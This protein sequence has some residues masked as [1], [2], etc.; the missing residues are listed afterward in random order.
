MNQPFLPLLVEPAE[1]EAKLGASNLLIV[2]LNRAEVYAQTHLPGAVRLEY[3]D[4]TLSN[5]PAMGLLPDAKRLSD[6]MSG[7]G[8][9]PDKHVVAYDAEGGSRAARLLWT[10]D[11]IGHRHYSLLNGGLL[12]WQHEGHRV[13]ETPTTAK[14]SIY[15]VALQDHAVADKTWIARH[16][17]DTNVVLLDARTAGE[18]D[19]SIS[20][21]ARGGH[22]PGAI[23]FDYVGAIDNVHHQRL[24][25][26]EG[27]RHE[28]ME[29]GVTP[30]KE[31]A[32]YC[33]THHRSAHLY[34]VL[35]YLGY[36]R[37]RGYPGSWSEWG[38][39]P[40]TPI[41]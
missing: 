16:L 23:N 32:V 1:L 35:K 38:N 2:D 25:P 26:V 4:L 20:R 33:Q 11:V 34:F 6:V 31:I 17:K 9:T 14:K 27:I 18:Y 36:P 29:L 12:A 24:R 7:I 3:V 13:E 8:L 22:I 5:P 15:K 28:L 30:E 41:E 40:D 37:V 19:G 39:S 10:L 21:A